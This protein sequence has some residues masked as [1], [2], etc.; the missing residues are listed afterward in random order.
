MYYHAI[1]PFRIEYMNNIKTH[2][3]W[4]PLA[5]LKVKT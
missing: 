4:V 2:I 5:S 1:Y 3:T